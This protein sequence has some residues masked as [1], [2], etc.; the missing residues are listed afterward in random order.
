[1]VGGGDISTGENNVS[2]A[3]CADRDDA[4]EEV[5][6]GELPA[7][8]GGFGRVQAPRMRRFHRDS[9]RSFVGTDFPAGSRIHRPLGTMGS[10]RHTRDL[11]GDCPPGA[12][13]WI[14]EAL[15]LE[16]SESA[17][18][19]LEPI[20]LSHGFLS[21]L[22]SHPLKILFDQV[23]VFGSYPGPVNVLKP[24]KKH[25]IS[26]VR[27]LPGYESGISVAEVH[28]PCRAWGEAGSHGKSLRVQVEGFK[29]S[30]VEAYYG[31]CESLFVRLNDI[32]IGE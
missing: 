13:T 18:V 7:G 17:G 26:T 27:S 14:N 20:R 9:L 3:F 4:M 6:E 32:Q 29:L 19:D 12:E 16:G 1:M 31:N 28:G 23:V 30:V 10:I 25:S 24:E 8:L 11:F 22:E 5:T 2:K 15:L 21:P